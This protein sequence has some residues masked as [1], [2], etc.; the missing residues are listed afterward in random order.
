MSYR[1]KFLYCHKE[2]NSQK[3]K[4]LGTCKPFPAK[5]KLFHDWDAVI[6][7]DLVFWE[8]NPEK[9]KALMFHELCHLG[10]NETTGQLESV[11]HDTSEFF[12]VWK[13]FG[14]WQGELK[15]ANIGTT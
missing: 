13:R 3:C 14:D 6:T 8:A 12:A 1:I 11:G 4:I 9:R 7:F 10:I 2:R 15:M 5:D